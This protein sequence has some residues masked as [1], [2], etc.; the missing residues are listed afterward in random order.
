MDVVLILLCLAHGQHSASVAARVVVSVIN[1]RFSFPIYF[2][3]SHTVL[4][5]LH[6]LSPQTF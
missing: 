4:S 5:S 6:F 1:E 2:N 3:F